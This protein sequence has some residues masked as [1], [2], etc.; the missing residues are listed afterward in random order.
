MSDNV[1]LKHMS[2]L[3]ADLHCRSH[4]PPGLRREMSGESESYQTLAL[5][6][7]AKP[8]SLILMPYCPPL[9]S[10]S[11]VGTRQGFREGTAGVKLTFSDKLLVRVYIG[12]LFGQ[13]LRVTEYMGNSST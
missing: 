13:D 2:S 7:A 11:E 6:R 5:V 1:G 12:T 8:L 10:R 3:T 9:E 4:R